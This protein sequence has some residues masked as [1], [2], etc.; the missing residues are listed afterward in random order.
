MTRPAIGP[1][2][3]GRPRLG[4]GLVR[5]VLR[6]VRHAVVLF[7]H[8]GRERARLQLPAGV[9]PG[10]GNEFTSRAFIDLLNR[11]QGPSGS[12]ANRLSDF[13]ARHG[14]SFRIGRFR[15]E[16][17]IAVG[18]PFP[19]NDPPLRI[20]DVVRLLSGG[21]KMI[22]VD[23]DGSRIVA[24]WLNKDG[25]AEEHSFPSHCVHRVSPLEGRQA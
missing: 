25:T 8:V 2:P 5:A 7:Q 13:K 17:L 23:F 11:E 21:P 16:D 4:S 6:K 20:G 1:K 3:R 14:K 10:A 19:P 15:A 9:K 12:E 18:E 22:V 24:S